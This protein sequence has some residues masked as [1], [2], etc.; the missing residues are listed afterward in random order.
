M[1]QL[2]FE[3]PMPENLSTAIYPNRKRDKHRVEAT[4]H[5]QE[6]GNETTTFHTSLGKHFATGY[7]RVVYGDHGPYLEFEERHIKMALS[8]K[9][10][11]K[12][13]EECYYE[14]L[15]PADG[16]NTKVYA[17]KKDV[18][19]LPNPPAGGHRGNRKEGYADY[20]PGKIYVSPYELI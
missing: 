15:V 3:L 20:K 17:Q 6:K 7:N 4:L 12:L 16:S 5:I 10:P 11:G 18:K 2:S 13:P 8:P 9:F 1:H 14:W 19:N